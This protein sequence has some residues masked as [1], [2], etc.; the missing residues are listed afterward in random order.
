MNYIKHICCISLGFLTGLSTVAQTNLPVKALPMI[1]APHTQEISAGEQV[2]SLPVK[3]NISFRASLS[4]DWLTCLSNDSTTLLLHCKQNLSPESRTASI[5]LS[6][7]EQHISQLFTLTQRRTEPLEYSTKSED[8][9]PSK[10]VGTCGKESYDIDR[11]FDGDDQTTVSISTANAAS[12]GEPL[13]LTYHFLGVDRL[14]G[15]CLTSSSSKT[16]KKEKR[17]IEILAKTSG[18]DSYQP[19]GRYVLEPSIDQ[20]TIE[21]AQPAEQPSAIEIRVSPAGTA[22]FDCAEISFYRNGNS[23][24]EVFTDAT[25]SKLKSDVTEEDITKMGNPYLKSIARQLF[26]GTY[27]IARRVSNYSCQLSVY[28]LSQQLKA[29]GKFYDQLAGVTGISYAPHSRYGVAVSG[30]PEGITVELN[31]VAWYVGKIGQN[32]EGGKPNIS[33][34]KLHNGLNIIDYTFDWAGLAYISYYADAN[35]E[36]YNDIRV[37]F[38]DGDINGYLSLDKS[39]EEMYNLCANAK[40]ICMDLI[41]DKVHSVWTSNGLEKYCRSTDG[42]YGYRQFMNILDSLVTWE[43][44]QLGLVKYNKV[45]RNKTMAYVNYTYFMFQSKLGVS[46][47]VDQEPKILNCKNLV[48]NAPTVIWGISHEWGH[49]HQM[50]PY[51]KWSGMAEVSNNLQSYNNVMKMGYPTHPS[52]KTWNRARKYFLLDEVYSSGKK[53]SQARLDAYKQKDQCNYNREFRQMCEKMKNGKIAPYA[54]KPEEAVAYCETELYETLCPLIMLHNYFTL[55]GHPDF[56]QDMYESLR[57]TELSNGSQIEKKGGIDK[58]EVIA[59]AQNNNVNNC[60]SVLTTKYPNS[61]WTK[62]KYI[63]RGHNQWIDNSVP[64]ILNFV[65][66]VSRLSGYNLFPYFEKW[67]YLRQLA[68]YKNDYGNKWYIMTPEMYNEF[69][70]DMEQLEANGEIKP[71][72]EHLLHDISY[73]KDLFQPKP[74]FPN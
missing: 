26:K 50:T 45:P 42:Q 18:H 8:I 38:I 17:D 32:F 49:Q 5:I 52:I 16:S 25:F 72:P 29:P 68:L 48:H 62:R 23:D 37:N 35:P 14:N 39:N 22:S 41:G 57:Q 66:K 55:N 20:Q 2:I 4:A 40:N 47:H 28:T 31:V 60:L 63:T 67:G 9:K 73:C 74:S 51:F 24:A 56:A 46:F 12:P 15:M 64:F 11:T 53:V 34:F 36:Q 43:H 30:I 3:A 21:F 69:K 70:E 6:N 58:Y 54:Q 1:V 65:R 71:M 10:G 61:C 33:T 7:E 19:L 44:T 27:D 59:C 13:C